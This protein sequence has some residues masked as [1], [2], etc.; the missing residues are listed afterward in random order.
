[1]TSKGDT[2][3]QALLRD[4][5]IKQNIRSQKNPYTKA[6][7]STLC[8]GMKLLDIG[9]GTGHILQDLAPYCAGSLFFG[10]DISDAMIQI[11]KSNNSSSPDVLF[12]RGDGM[13]L[14]FSGLSLNIVINRLAEYSP[15]EAY[16]VLQQG[17]Y[18]FEYG[19]GP[20]A[21]REIKE[22]FADRIDVESFCIPKVMGKWK[23]EVCQGVVDAGF[24]I[25]RFEDYR[26]QAHFGDEED[27]MDTIEMVPLVKDF[28]R[29]RDRG[30]VKALVEKYGAKNGIATTWH[31]YVLKARKQ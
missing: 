15:H 18:F 21:D 19:L 5:A 29:D 26:E 11:A 12:I 8:P 13:A 6:I 30:I 20:D 17:G 27:I 3:R 7:L 25:E 2:E 22:F 9:C 23:E 10:L 28:D 1:M 31:Y 16:R 4:K 24:K 14:P